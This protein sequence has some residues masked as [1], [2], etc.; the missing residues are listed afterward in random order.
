MHFVSGYKKGNFVA[1]SQITKFRV[2]SMCRPGQTVRENLPF[3]WAM[4]TLEKSL[5]K[6]VGTIPLNRVEEILTIPHTGYSKDKPQI[7]TLNKQLSI[8]QHGKNRKIIFLNCDATNGDSGAQILQ[9]NENGYELVGIHVAPMGV[10]DSA[11]GVAVL[12]FRIKAG[13]RFS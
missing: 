9:H 7:L 6:L 3:D 5:A 11:L 12:N 10:G 13:D 4:L 2:S 1:H 8:V